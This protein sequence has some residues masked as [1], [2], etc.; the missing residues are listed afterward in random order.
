M[1]NEIAYRPVLRGS[2]FPR[3]TRRFEESP[4][5]NQPAV[6]MTGYSLP[7][8]I[9]VLYRNPVVTSMPEARFPFVSRDHKSRSYTYGGTDPFVMKNSSSVDLFFKNN[10]NMIAFL[11]K[12]WTEMNLPV[13]KDDKTGL[14]L[15]DFD[16]ERT[17][18]ILNDP[19][20]PASTI[21]AMRLI[22]SNVEILARTSLVRVVIP[23]WWVVSYYGQDA[24]NSRY[25][26]DGLRILERAFKTIIKTAAFKAAY[27]KVLANQGD[28]LT[29]SIGFP[30]YAGVLDSELR[31]VTRINALHQY[32]GLAVGNPKDW[33]ELKVRASKLGRTPF[34]RDY[35]FAVASLRRSSAGHKW[36]HSFGPTPTGLRAEMDIL[37]YNTTRVAFQAS[38]LQNLIMSPMQSLMKAVKSC[39][40]GMTFDREMRIK[41]ASIM[42]SSSLSIIESDYSN[43][44]RTIPHDVANKLFDIFGR[45]T[46]RPNYWSSVLRATNTDV[47][48]LWPDYLP[49][50]KTSLWIF[51][52]AKLGLLS[53]LKITSDEGTFINL[54]I[55]ISGWLKNGI[56][57]EQQVYEYLTV[58]TRG[59]NWIS[60][61][62]IG[63]IPLLISSDDTLMLANTPDKARAMEHAFQESAKAA[64]VKAKIAIG[65]KYLMRHMEE[66]RDAPVIGRVFQNTISGEDPVLNPGQF[67]VGLVTRTDG[68][69]GCKTIDPFG[70]GKRRRISLLERDLTVLLFSSLKEQFSTASSPIPDS[71]RFCDLY[72]TALALANVQQDYCKV[73]DQEAHEIDEF[74]HKVMKDFAAA[75]LVL[76]S[77]ESKA[78]IDSYIAKL[79]NDEHNPTSARTLEEIVEMEPSLRPLLT[80]LK[81]KEHTFYL[82]A[83]KQLGIDP[84]ID[85]A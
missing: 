53:G 25:F 84:I 35:P 69:A 36:A 73:R 52:A 30:S 4:D 20:T 49:N 9:R 78:A 38:Y 65:D 5:A 42:K 31:P 21:S 66:G 8:I 13:T 67:M 17:R 79:A 72:L 55:N 59:S 80:A 22:A 44:D 11:T 32:Q 41:V 15:P 47:T 6:S 40:P 18:L 16:A 68:L 74:R 58:C 75:Q 71:I 63:D 29:S 70:T 83:M 39:I 54:L 37:G 10:N 64:G 85:L 56:M 33:N 82:Y 19:A 27:S 26:E 45:L 51:N 60:T 48:L 76:M 1:P 3:K 62:N 50:E 81:A 61:L 14:T 57:N 34:E 77:S 43:Y 23:G 12:T 28:P 2:P 24:P 46:K 7:D